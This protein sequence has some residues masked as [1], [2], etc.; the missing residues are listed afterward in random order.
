MENKD[1]KEYKYDAFISYRHAEL[2]QFVAEN[3]HKLLETFKVPR[4]AADSIKKQKKNKI[5][6]VFR[7]RDELPLASSLSE[8]IQN[9]LENSEFLIVICS[10]RTPESLWVQ[11]EIKTFISMHGRDK[12]L[13]V[14]IEGEPEQSFPR[15]LRFETVEKVLEDGTKCTAEQEVEPLAADV[16]G[17]NK[18]EVYKNLKAELL[19]LTAPLLGCSYDDLK[20]RHRERKIKRMMTASLTAAAVFLVFGSISTAMALRIQKQSVLIKEQSEE[21]EEQYEEVLKRQAYTMADTSTELLAEGNR[22]AALLV[23]KEALTEMPYTEQAQYALTEAVRVY[24]NGSTIMPIHLLQMSTNIDFFFTSPEGKRILTVDITGKLTVWEAVSGTEICSLLGDLS[25]GS[26]DENEFG[27]LDEKHIV[28]PKDEEV[29]IYNVEE[30][31]EELCLPFES[32]YAFAI[33][34]D[35]KLL[36]VSDNVKVSIIDTESYTVKEE[37]IP[38]EEWDW[39]R[40]IVF[41]ESGTLLACSVV[42]DFSTGTIVVWDM[43]NGECIREAAYSEKDI[44]DMLFIGEEQLVISLQDDYDEELNRNTTIELL[45]VYTGAVKWNNNY[46]DV[47]IDELQFMKQRN[48]I[49]C[50]SY[51]GVTMLSAEDGKEGAKTEFDSEIVGCIPMAEK[52]LLLMLREGR[53]V[54][55]WCDTGDTYENSAYFQTNSS[56]MAAFKLGSNYY[57]S[58]PHNSNA[59]TVYQSTMGIGVEGIAEFTNTVDTVM[60]DRAGDTYLIQIYGGSE[61]GA[62]YLIDA[63]TNEKLAGFET[64]TLMK[65]AFFIGEND[66]QIGILT[67][68]ALYFYDRKGNYLRQLDFDAYRESMVSITKDGSRFVLLLDGVLKCFE[69]DTLQEAAQLSLENSDALFAMGEKQQYCVVI[70]EAEEE[71]QVLDFGT[72]EKISSI[73]INSAFV[74]AVCMDGEEE[75]IFVTYRDNMVEVYDRQNLELK[76]TYTELRDEVLLAENVDGKDLFVL[77][78]LTESYLCKKD[79][80]EVLARIPGYSAVTPDGESV[81]VSNNMK[82]VKIPLYETEELLEEADRQ[83]KGRVLSDEERERYHLGEIAQKEETEQGAAKEEQK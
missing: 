22:V 70:S 28:F 31:K 32:R 43:Q 72:A 5:N 42:Y 21:I 73:P 75:Y 45:D 23:A 15:E 41:N 35:K 38:E 1:T 52:N 77:Y 46:D 67:S 54:Y 61:E 11:K 2:D 51:Y 26:I 62:A 66:E 36:A 58:L 13:A 19:R 65:N 34:T 79:N 8:N 63:K 29:V 18:K 17:K 78:G 27:F 56:N 83:L 12:V 76:H 37:Y 44:W 69:T 47:W 71:L 16:R 40:K 9:A 74:S 82:V 20:Q 60:C 80:F 81:L 49:V 53:T 48:E 39:T 6:R 59:V 24:E 10:P 55:V 64:D 68:D 33:H 50:L 30:Q 57:A 7:D 14:L 25:Y 4:I 3:L